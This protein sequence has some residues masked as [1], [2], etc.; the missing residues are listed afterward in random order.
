MAVK[1][2]GVF[3]RAVGPSIAAGTSP[4]PPVALG[5]H[6]TGETRCP[7]PRWVQSRQCLDSRHVAGR[8]LMNRPLQKLRGCVLDQGEPFE[9]G[10]RALSLLR[11]LTPDV[12]NK[13][14][15]RH[16]LH[17]LNKTMLY[18]HHCTAGLGSSA[19]NIPSLLPH[20]PAWLLKTQGSPCELL[21]GSR[22]HV[23]MVLV[24]CLCK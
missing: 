12:V 9:T 15:K 23:P 16:F 7:G 1:M 11:T 18:P 20:H 24:V 22:T 3:L 17:Q 21:Q 14:R 8:A 4:V 10:A 2:R 5:S 19:R 13:H 6:S